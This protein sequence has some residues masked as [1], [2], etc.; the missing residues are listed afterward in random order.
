MREGLYHLD[1]FHRRTKPVRHEFTVNG[2]TM[3][4]D[5]NNFDKPRHTGS[6]LSF[7][8]MAVHRFRRRDFTLIQNPAQTAMHLVNNFLKKEG[9]VVCDAAFLLATPAIFGYAFNPVSFYFCL[10]A[11]EHVATII[12]VNNTFGE[13]R[14]FLA[15]GTQ[16]A[17]TKNFYV[18]P[19]ISPVA[20]FRMKIPPPDDNLSIRIDT[21]RK[22]EPELEA[23]MLGR[24]RPIRFRTLLLSALLFPL[25]SVKVIV[26][27]H[28]HAMWLFFKGVPHFNK[29]AADA[30]ALHSA[31]RSKV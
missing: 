23:V 8:R 27:I 16:L 10:K 11:G 9:N 3:L 15:L 17:E 26:L 5:V 25:Y 22:G 13:Q 12:E 4:V 31:L 28:W 2:Y 29:E 24:W 20:D 7:E 1:V 18:S 14:H 21:W 30:A 6:L 19:F